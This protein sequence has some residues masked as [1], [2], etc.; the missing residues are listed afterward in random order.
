MSPC[1]M[2]ACPQHTAPMTA[3]VLTVCSFRLRCRQQR[4]ARRSR[5]W[6]SPTAASGSSQRMRSCTWSASSR[7]RGPGSSKHPVRAACSLA[8]RSRPARSLPR[9][10]RTAS[11]QPATWQRTR[12]SKPAP[13]HPNAPLVPCSFLPPPPPAPPVLRAPAP[14]AL[15]ALPLACSPLLLPCLPA[16]PIAPTLQHCAP[17]V[18]QLA[19]ACLPRSAQTSTASQNNPPRRVHVG[20]PRGKR[21]ACV[22]HTVDSTGRGGVNAAIGPCMPEHESWQQLEGL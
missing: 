21:G 3:G 1:S 17:A 7:C 15:W 4:R 2:H 16:H 8:W 11:R 5:L 10:S 19:S 9:R 13:A 14:R 18:Q 6:R 12:S 20:V 22:F